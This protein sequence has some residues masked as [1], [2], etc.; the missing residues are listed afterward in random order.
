MPAARLGA[1]DPGPAERAAQQL[2]L[3]LH[4]ELLQREARRR[5]S[6]AMPAAQCRQALAGLPE[7][8]E[9]AEPGAAARPRR[10]LPPPASSHGRCPDCTSPS[11]A[12]PGRIR[13]S[14]RAASQTTTAPAAAPPPRQPARSGNACT[15][16]APPHAEPADGAATGGA[17]GNRAS[18]ISWRIAAA[19]SPAGA[20]AVALPADATPAQLSPNCRSAVAALGGG[21]ACGKARGS[22][23]RASGTGRRA[24]A[25][26]GAQPA[27]PQPRTQAANPPSQPQRRRRG[28]RLPPAAAQAAARLNRHGHAQTLSLLPRIARED[29]ASTA[30]VR[31][32][33]AGVP[34]GGGA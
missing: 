17:S 26:A 32:S 8:G 7:R 12:G 9:R 34:L 11:G 22:R 27:Q 10:R 33:A 25:D 19:C 6:P 28:R 14:G 3:R 18:R 16:A 30:I 31:R 23:R 1:A 5:R 2:P 21:S 29:R 20:D 15:C 24:H 13:A 4:G